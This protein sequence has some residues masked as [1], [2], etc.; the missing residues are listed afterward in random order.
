VNIRIEKSVGYGC[1]EEAIKALKKCKPIFNGAKRT[2]TPI[3]NLSQPYKF[4]Y[5]GDD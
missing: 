3:F 1:D 4:E 2:C 5:Q